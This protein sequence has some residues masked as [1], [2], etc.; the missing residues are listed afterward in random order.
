MLIQRTH[1]LITLVFFMYAR[2]SCSS[3]VL[4]FHKLVSSPQSAKSQS[5]Y[6]AVKSKSLQ[7]SRVQVWPLFSKSESHYYYY[8]SS[9]K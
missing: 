2:M 7:S 8:K 9:E 3:K 1:W 5:K 6:I 4:L